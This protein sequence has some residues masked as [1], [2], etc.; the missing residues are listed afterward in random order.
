MDLDQEKLTQIITNLVSNAIKHTPRGGKVALSLSISPIG[1]HLLIHVQDTGS[2]ISAEDLPY[3]FDQFY[4]SKRAAIGGTGIGLALARNLSELL[5]GTLSVESTLDLGSTFTLSLPI[6]KHAQKPVQALPERAIAIS[7]AQEEDIHFPAT[8]VQQPGK[9][10]ILIVEDHPEIAQYVASCLTS[11]YQI[12]N[13]FNG[14]DGVSMAYENIPD[15]IISDVMMPGKDGFELT[16][17]LKKDIQTSHI[18]IILLTGRGDHD[19]LLTGIEYGAEAYVTKPFD[20]TE[21]KLRVKKLLELR[22]NLSQYYRSHAD[23]VEPEKPVQVSARENEFMKKIRSIIEEHI[24]DAQFNMNM[25]SKYMAMS[26]PQLHRKIIALTGESTGKFVRSVRLAKAKEL[27]MNSDLTISEIA[28]ETGFSEP[29]YFTRIFSKEFN[30]T[31]TEFRG[32][33]I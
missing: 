4:Q 7:E 31:P 6:T 21:L 13:A 25:L 9:P 5:G 27:L 1:N 19:A 20:P 11:E 12:L 10:I 22:A 28:Y 30:M 18:P 8:D 17:I 3:I 16:S 23:S 33:L 15:L 24:N 26:H 29:G 32:S 14:D 2:G